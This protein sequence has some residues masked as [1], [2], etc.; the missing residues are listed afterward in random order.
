MDMNLKGALG[1]RVPKR[2]Y[3]FSINWL[4]KNKRHPVRSW[5][6]STLFLNT[7]SETIF[8]HFSSKFDFVTSVFI[9]MESDVSLAS[10]GVSLASTGVSPT[11]AQIA[12]A[13]KLRVV[14]TDIA[15]G[16][17]ALAYNKFGPVITGGDACFELIVPFAETYFNECVVLLRTRGDE[18]LDK[19]FDEMLQIGI[20]Y[21]VVCLFNIVVM[22][23]MSMLQSMNIKDVMSVD[24]NSSLSAVKAHLMSISN[25]YFDTAKILALTGCTKDHF[26][27]EPDAKTYNFTIAKVQ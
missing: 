12:L 15:L 26:H 4:V 5:F 25:K 2:Q 3:I 7:R 24:R 27:G 22:C 8:C 20:K 14:T 16:F 11:A 17:V 1:T 23:V 10:T 6:M 21:D 9:N 19:H 13:N 18:Y